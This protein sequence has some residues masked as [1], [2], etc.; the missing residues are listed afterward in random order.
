MFPGRSGY[1]QEAAL[2]VRKRTICGTASRTDARL[3]ASTIAQMLSV[4]WTVCRAVGNGRVDHAISVLCAPVRFQRI[5]ASVTI[6]TEVDHQVYGGNH[7]QVIRRF[8]E[9]EIQISK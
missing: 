7:R 8:T 3:G 9:A 4:N 5:G 6:A 1:P 2:S